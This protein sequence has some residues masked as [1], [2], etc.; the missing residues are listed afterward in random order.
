MRHGFLTLIAALIVAASWPAWAQSGGSP[1]VVELYTSEGCSSCPPADAL[2]FD[3]REEDDVIALAFH[4][5]YWDYLGWQD[6]FAKPDFTNRQRAYARSLGSP[7]V[8]TPQLVV[9][10]A[11][12][13]VGSARGQVFAAIDSA[14]A[15]PGINLD[16]GLAMGDHHSLVVSIPA[17]AYNGEATIW[18][19][20]YALNEETPVSAGE[21]AGRILRHANVVEEL[22]AIGMWKGEAMDITLPWEAIEGSHET[23]EDFGCAIIVQPEGLGPILGARKIT[24][25]AEPAS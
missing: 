10:G 4:V 14:R 6:R 1:V 18:F 24:W 17:A 12:H 21:N 23:Y 15:H 7:M 9:N 20:R 11:D 16:I 19:V 13:V 2:L 3:L 5:D 25:E 22:T 8:Y